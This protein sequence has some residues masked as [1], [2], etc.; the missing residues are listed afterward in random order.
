MNIMTT[1]FVK[2]I[3]G[4]DIAINANKTRAAR[5]NIA[6]LTRTDNLAEA[7]RLARVTS[8][9]LGHMTGPER[10][11]LIT[12]QRFKTTNHAL[13]AKIAA[14]VAGSVAANKWLAEATRNANVKADAE[15]IL[16]KHYVV[17][18]TNNDGYVVTQRNDVPKTAYQGLV[19]LGR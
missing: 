4:V 19:S 3:N 6:K 2:A 5:L 17:T 14:A 1:A 15:Q 16:R 18:K 9:Q 8:E 7:A 10:A 11:A 13:A 12:E